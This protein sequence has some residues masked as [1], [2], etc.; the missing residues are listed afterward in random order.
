MFIA[1]SHQQGG[2]FIA[3]SSAAGVVFIAAGQQ[4][5]RVF[6]AAGQQQGGVFIAAG[7]QQVVCYL[8]AIQNLQSSLHERG[9]L[10]VATLA[11]AYGAVFCSSFVTPAIIYHTGVKAAIMAAWVGHCI[12]VLC[13]YFPHWLTL[14]PGSLVMGV[15]SCPLWTS[16]EIYMTSLARQEVSDQRRQTTFHASFSRLNG[17][18]FSIFMGSQFSGN[19]ISS[20]ILFQSSYNDSSDAE[21]LAALDADEVKQCGIHFCSSSGRQKKQIA[22]PDP[23]VVHMLL[24]VFLVCELCGLAVTALY[25]PDLQ[26]PDWTGRDVWRKLTSHLESM[27]HPRLWLLVPFLIS[28]MMNLAIEVGTFTQ[29]SERPFS[30]HTTR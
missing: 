11:C 2:V 22:T 17:A 7:Q 16:L 13:N 8:Q 29:V 27:T 5:V 19:L 9:G 24:T 23:E 21:L 1:A 28:R 3:C 25:L 20:T 4:Q 10:G 15:L 30:S 12:F 6:I 18:F 14:I 26:Q